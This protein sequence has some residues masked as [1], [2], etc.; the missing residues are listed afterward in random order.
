MSPSEYSNIDFGDGMWGKMTSACDGPYGGFTGCSSKLSA[1][2]LYSTSGMYTVRWGGTCSS[3]KCVKFTALGTIKVNV[4]NSQ[5]I[6]LPG[7]TKYTDADFGFSFWY[8]SGWTV[9]NSG[10]SEHQIYYYPGGTVTKQLTV[11]SNINPSNAIAIEEFYSP[12][13]EITV[14]GI[15]PSHAGA[16]NQPPEQHYYFDASTHTWMVSTPATLQH[17]DRYGT[18]YTLPANT[19]AADVSHNTMGGLHMLPVDCLT[20]VIPISAHNFVIFSYNCS[21]A[22]DDRGDYLAKTI[23]ATNPSVATPVSAAEQIATIQAEQRA[24]VGQ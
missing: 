21:S 12:T 10:V 13:K 7:M 5:S 14:Q 24:Y 15:N 18:P 9:T 17:D 23:L 11:R 16:S 20:K 19:Q 3:D 8:P 4:V 22:A 1:Q 6:S 2:H